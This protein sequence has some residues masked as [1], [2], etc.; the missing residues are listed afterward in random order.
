VILS[1]LVEAWLL[2]AASW[3]V[4]AVASVRLGLP[5]L[6]PSL[7]AWRGAEALIVTLFG[8]LWFASLGSGEWWLLFLLIGGLVAGATVSAAPTRGPRATVA[9]VID[10]L[11]YVLAGGILAARLG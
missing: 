8:S 5:P 1:R 11:R 3:L 9:V 7:A 2:V 4:A 6:S 10:L